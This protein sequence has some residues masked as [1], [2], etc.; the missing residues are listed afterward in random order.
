M[1]NECKNGSLH[2]DTTSVNIAQRVWPPWSMMSIVVQLCKLM[3]PP[4][5]HM[6]SALLHMAAKQIQHYFSHLVRKELFN[7]VGVN[8]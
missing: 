1:L 5:A 4:R 6:C 2:L 3:F 8:V 7:V